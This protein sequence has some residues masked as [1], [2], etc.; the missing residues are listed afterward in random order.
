MAGGCRHHRLQ[1]HRRLQ[2]HRCRRCVVHMIFKLIVICIVF[3][4]FNNLDLLRSM[5][6]NCCMPRRRG[7]GA[8]AAV[9]RRRPPWLA[10]ACILPSFSQLYLGTS[11]VRCPPTPYPTNNQPPT[12]PIVSDFVNNWRM[13]TF[14]VAILLCTCMVGRHLCCVV[15]QFHHLG[16]GGAR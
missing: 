3:S 5:S 15:A 4:S 11:R 16:V 14:Q 1:L 12:H 13:R 2:P 9:G 8:M 6:A 7:W 10:G